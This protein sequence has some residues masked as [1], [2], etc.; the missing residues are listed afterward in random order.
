MAS[1]R[2]DSQDLAINGGPRAVPSFEGTG[3][4]KIGV[5]EF[6]ELADAWGFGEATRTAVRAAVEAE[7]IPTPHLNRYYNPR[8]SKVAALEAYARELFG[9]SHALAV[10]SGTSALNAAYVGCGIG[11]GDEVIVPGYTFFATAAAVVAC[12][13]IPVIADIDESLCLD[14]EDVARKITPRT[15]AIVPVHM[16]GN[17][18]DMDA[19][20]EVASRHGL[21]VIEDS[22]QACGGKYKGRFLGA[23]GDA[24]CF[25]ISGYKIT[26]CGEA[27][28]VLT[29][30]EWVYTRAQSQHDTA[31]CWRPDRY[32]RE[33]RPGELFCGQNYRLS[34]LEGAVNLVQLRKTDAQ[35]RRYNAAMQRVASGVEPTA[36]VTLRPSNDINGDVGYR[37]ALLASAP[38]H[39][40]RLAEAL[41]AEGVPAGGRGTNVSRDWH[42][43]AYW[44]QILEQKTATAEGCPFT[45]PYHQ[46]DLP[47][48]SE[49]MCPR[50][51]DLIGRAVF[52]SIDQWWTPGDCDSV[53]RAINKVCRVL[54]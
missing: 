9:V 24:G 36:H 15:K 2:T 43:Y 50:T 44:E 27:G 6:M 42:L 37:L 52:V 23:I 3:E 20:R 35:A 16:G 45:C 46:G 53:A 19:I 22:A 25:S 18:C 17:C 33:K 29:D 48:Y 5:E 4:P 32:A 10:N 39:A 21:L 14:P 31:A 8:P 28:L 51:L 12:R 11:P 30:D 54:G 34:E 49:D 38:D 1:L 47:P 7:P 26:G 40:E 41:R 13:A